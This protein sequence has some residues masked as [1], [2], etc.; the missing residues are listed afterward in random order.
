MQHKRLLRAAFDKVRF[1]LNAMIPDAAFQSEWSQLENKFVSKI[2]DMDLETATQNMKDPWGMEELHDVQSIVKRLAAISSAQDRERRARVMLRA[3]AAT[4]EKLESA[5]LMDQEDATQYL[6]QKKAAGKDWERQVAA[7][8][9]ARY[10]RGME[11]ARAFLG[12]RFDI[13]DLHDN[14]LIMREVLQMR[15][16]L[17]QDAISSDGAHLHADMP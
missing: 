14:K 9:A 2:L 5:L 11:A 4:F 8:R 6:N 17:E 13:V 3:E 1:T 10:T 15:L 16:M 12:A 7:Y